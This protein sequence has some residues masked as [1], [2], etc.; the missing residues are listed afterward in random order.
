MVWIEFIWDA[1]NNPV[2]RIDP[3]GLADMLLQGIVDKNG[4]TVKNIATINT[5]NET[6]NLYKVTINGKTTVYS[7]NIVKTVN[8]LLVID[9]I[10]LMKDFKLTEKQATHQAGDK[11]GSQT[12]AAMAFAFVYNPLSFIRSDDFPHGREYGANI[13][14]NGRYYTFEQ[15]AYG[16]TS[17]TRVDLYKSNSKYGTMVAQIHTHGAGRHGYTNDLLNSDVN[18][19]IVDQYLATPLGT[20]V[21]RNYISHTGWWIFTKS[22]FEAQPIQP[23]T[24]QLPSDPRENWLK[25]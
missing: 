16:R 5:P 22:I 8:E 11:F 24:N 21:R 17:G 4:G 2:N 7:S 23:I 6:I 25:Y 19:S 15:I 20:L 12:Y 13:Y 1:G 9:N 10:I 3:W 14:K 18:K